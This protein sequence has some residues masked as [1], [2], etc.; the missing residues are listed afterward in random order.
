MLSKCIENNTSF[1]RGIIPLRIAAASTPLGRHGQIKENQSPAKFLR[2]LNRLGS[3]AA[4]L[5]DLELCFGLDEHPEQV[6]IFGLSSQI[7]MP[8]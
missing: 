3:V 6:A 4:S 8:A 1:V 5:T 2:F 7:R